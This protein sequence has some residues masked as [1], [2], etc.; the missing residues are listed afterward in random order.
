MNEIETKRFVLKIL[1]EKYLSNLFKILSNINVIDTLNMER[2]TKIEDTI[3]ML[4]EYYD[5]FRKNEKFPYEIIDK[6]SNEFVGVFL[7]KLDL[8][9]EDSFEF[10]I[11]I[12][13]KFWNKGIYTEILPYMTEVAFNE[14]K[15]GNFR[16]FVMEKNIAS[17]TVLEKCNFTLEKIFE[18]EGIDGKIYSYLKKNPL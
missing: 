16:G 2:H 6:E 10:T 13:E 5:G 18:V 12:D 14:I 4:N 7:I 9:D 3:N 1:E 15:T 17:R 8:Y 11:Y